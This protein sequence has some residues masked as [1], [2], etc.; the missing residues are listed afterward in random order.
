MKQMKAK[1]WLLLGAGL[2]LVLALKVLADGVGTRPATAEEKEF[3]KSVYDT[4]V[5]AL[6]PG[7]A[8]WTNTGD[9]SSVKELKNT[10]MGS[11]KYPRK[12]DYWGSWQDNQ[13]LQ[14]SQLKL[15]E[16]MKDIAKVP[17]A[18]IE[19]YVKDTTMKAAAKDTTLRM[20]VKA[21]T[22]YQGFYGKFTQQ[23]AIA[24][25]QVFRSDSKF[26]NDGGWEEGVTYVFLGKNWKQVTKGGDYMEAAAEKA[27]P[28][29]AVQTIMVQIKGDP[30]RA[31]Q[32]L[33]K[34]NWEALKKLL[35]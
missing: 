11:E 12:V 29:L 24:G 9:S 6:P 13:K 27:L 17:P 5:K 21:N 18:Q 23:P 20:D 32:I 22:L 10:D 28:S 33:D 34:T 2:G 25:G 8:G 19:Q 16:A 31:K 7:P 30:E 3:Y 14:E 1:G 26:N 35:K 4:I 15:A